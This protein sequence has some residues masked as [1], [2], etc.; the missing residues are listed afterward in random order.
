MINYK[1]KI[2][3]IVRTSADVSKNK[4]NKNTHK[5]VDLYRGLK[6]IDEIKR[7]Y[8]DELRLENG[9]VWEIHDRNALYKLRH[10]K[11][12][13]HASLLPEIK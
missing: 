12:L 9:E 11:K 6:V 10:E 13:C 8:F 3:E 7:T 5:K 2:V 4:A 1:T